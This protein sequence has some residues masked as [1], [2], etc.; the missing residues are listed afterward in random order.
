MSMVHNNILNIMKNPLLDVYEDISEKPTLHL[1]LFEKIGLFSCLIISTVILIISGF[2]FYLDLFVKMNYFY[3]LIDLLIILMCI[4]AIYFMLKAIKRKI[5]TDVLIDTAFQ[6]GVYTRLK[7]LIE[8]IAK[9]HIDGE[10]ILDRISNIDIKVQN[11]LKDQYSKEVEQREF[12]KEPIAVGTSIRFVFKSMFL[13][14]ITMIFFNLI[15]N[16]NLGNL[17]SYSVL[18]IFL[19][20]W[21]FITSEYNMWKESSAWTA[22]F[23]PI[24]VVPITIMLLG[25]LLHYNI[26]IAEIYVSVGLYIVAYYLW[27]VHLTTGSLPFLITKKQERST[28]DFFA[29]QKKGILKEYM[30][31]IKMRIEQQLRKYEENQGIQYPWKK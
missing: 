23:F 12:L 15:L 27:A 2:S 10:M 16:F 5:I 8:N 4:W 14:I 17:T 26:L 9:A 20:W 18:L 13:L 30:G 21:G 25:A 22:V 24:L 19:I 7:P 6:D 1:T 11:L 31:A 3:A 29:L 28:N